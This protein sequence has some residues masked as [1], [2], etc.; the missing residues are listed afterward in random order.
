[1]LLWGL[2]GVCACCA[3]AMRSLCVR[4]AGASR[5]N[6]PPRGLPLAL[7]CTFDGYKKCAC[8]RLVGVWGASALF[9]D[10]KIQT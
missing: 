7:L 1:M 6:A 4:T 9:F 3:L 8:S 10:E 2:M 5:G